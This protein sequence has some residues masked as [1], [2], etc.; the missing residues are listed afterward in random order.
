MRLRFVLSLLFLSVCFQA[1]SAE[2][3]PFEDGEKITYHFYWG[4]FMVG[5]GTFEVKKGEDAKNLIFQ[6]SIRSNDFISAIYPVND[7]LTSEFDP[8]KK[9]SLNFEQDLNEG[10]H[11]TWEETFFYYDLAKASTQS[12]MDGETKWFEI[13]SGGVQDKLSTIYFMRMINWDGLESASTMIGNDK[14]NREIVITKVREE[15]IDLDSYKKIPTMV[16]EPNSE[17]LG[18]F[19]KRGKMTVWVSNDQFKI[20]IR[21]LAKLDV[22]TIRAELVNIEGISEWP[23]EKE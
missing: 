1:H 23:Y 9:R 19:G 20:P 18:K 8:K 2:A 17:Y 22:G 21:I 11:R 5:R 3:T 13:P 15:T 10:K 16:V 14:V 6:A 4:I 12:Y 7:V